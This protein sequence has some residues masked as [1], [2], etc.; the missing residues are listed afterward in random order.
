MDNSIKQLTSLL[1]SNS[2]PS[3]IIIHHM[4]VLAYIKAKQY[5]KIIGHVRSC[6][7]LLENGINYK[8]IDWP[9]IGEPIKETSPEFIKVCSL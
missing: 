2:F 9:L 4:L 5:D 1:E 6:L 3:P 7:Q 8:P